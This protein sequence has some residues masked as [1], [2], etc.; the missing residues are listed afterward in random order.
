MTAVLTSLVDAGQDPSLATLSAV[1]TIADAWIAL[2]YMERGGERNRTLSIVKARGSAHSN[3]TREFIMSAEGCTL[4]DVYTAGGEVLLGTARMEREAREKLEE[5]L[6]LLNHQRR[7]RELQALLSDAE[8]RQR[9]AA[10]Q[11]EAARDELEA[12]QSAEA[13]RHKM[14]VERR[15]RVAVSRLADAAGPVA[16]DAAE[17]RQQ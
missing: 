8:A 7:Q 3:Q 16:A 9:Q 13:E 11:L 14:L 15:E 1:S 10:L 5:Q 6:A 12:L 4:A 2:G 17:G